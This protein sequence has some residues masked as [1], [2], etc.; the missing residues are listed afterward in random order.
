MCAKM[1]LETRTKRCISHRVVKVPHESLKLH[2]AESP[3]ALF[4]LITGAI[5]STLRLGIDTTGT[6]LRCLINLE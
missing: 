5:W 4:G 1:R 6:S 3:R 2:F